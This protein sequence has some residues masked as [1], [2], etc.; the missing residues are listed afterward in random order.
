MTGQPLVSVM[1]IFLNAE[2]FLDEAVQS[3]L[4]QTYDNWELLLVDDGSTDG[5]TAIARHYADRHPHKIRYL[6]HNGH[7]N[8][9]TGASRNV[10]LSAARGEF[11]AFLDSD[12]VWVHEKLDQQVAIMTAHPEVAMLFGRSLYWRSW[13]PDDG[14]ADSMSAPGVPPNTIVNPPALLL[15][16]LDPRGTLR[17]C[18]SSVMFRRDVGQRLG[19]FDET[20]K[21]LY[22]DI[23]FLAKIWLEER[24][25]VADAWWDRRREH[26]G[27]LVWVA[28]L[29]A[30]GWYASLVFF[31]EWL[32]SYLAGRGQQ[33]SEVWRALQRALWPHRHPFL[34]RMRTRSTAIVRRVMSWRPA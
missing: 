6:E 1:T 29:D 14:R 10:G 21:G 11:I 31:L 9:G 33:D 30:R 26:A 28:G 3:V 20:F 25:W 24:V 13:N 5:S 32:E 8:R 2:R 7:Q 15:S 18:L 4:S 12:D 27:S 17:L 34:F 23:A 22:E 19:G 16:W